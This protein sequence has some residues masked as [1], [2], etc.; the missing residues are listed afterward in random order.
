M[1]KWLNGLSKWNEQT[2]QEEPTNKLAAGHTLTQIEVP[3]G[4]ISA[5]NGKGGMDSWVIST[6]K[7][8]KWKRLMQ[9]TD[10]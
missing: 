8:I 10:F 7:K 5:W 6:V 1:Y 3:D 4:L 9:V 2:D